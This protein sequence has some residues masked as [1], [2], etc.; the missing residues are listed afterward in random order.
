M[1]V[2]LV[3]FKHELCVQQLNLTGQQVNSC[4][5]GNMLLLVNIGQGN[6]L[7]AT[8]GWGNMLLATTGWGNMLLATTG[9]GN[10]LVIRS[11]RITT[12]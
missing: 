1:N 7:L 6:M 8:T 3:S 12:V 10:M 11:Q 4:C 5:L 2:S 9:W